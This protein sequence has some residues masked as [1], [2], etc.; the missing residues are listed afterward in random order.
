M[1]KDSLATILLTILSF[2]LCFWHHTTT[3]PGKFQEKSKFTYHYL[4]K[5]K[6]I[7]FSESENNFHS[8]FAYY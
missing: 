1:N 6:K 3:H 8:Q 7:S 4:L 2:E 5:T